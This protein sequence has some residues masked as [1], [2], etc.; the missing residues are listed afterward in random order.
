MS[1]PDTTPAALDRLADALGR[2]AVS[3]PHLMTAVPSVTLRAIAARDRARAQGTEAMTDD[4]LLDA[5]TK[6]VQQENDGVFYFTDWK[7][8]ALA[9]RH[10]LDAHHASERERLT[11][12]LAQLDP[13]ITEGTAIVRNDI[14]QEAMYEAEIERLRALL[15][16]ALP[17][18]GFYERDQWWNSR[19]DLAA[20]IR[21]ALATR[22]ILDAHHASERAD[23][24][25]LVRRLAYRVRHDGHGTLARQAATYL[26]EH[27][28]EGDPM[29]DQYAVPPDT[30]DALK[31]RAHPTTETP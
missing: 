4:A 20:R 1:A 21:E 10:I 8:V 3:H 31:R 16:E 11:Q 15:A 2:L 19:H 23:L 18:V 5:A 6:L 25:A 12:R 26:I 22:H 14:E 29:R 27:G 30:A 13:L 17:C 9:T 28:L 24:A 7:K